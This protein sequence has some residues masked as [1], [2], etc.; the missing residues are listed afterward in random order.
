MLSRDLH[1]FFHFS[2]RAFVVRT[3]GYLEDAK[4]LLDDLA[5]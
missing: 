1:W 2:P 4:A 3:A 5:D